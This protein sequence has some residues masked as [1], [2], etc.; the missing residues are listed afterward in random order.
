VTVATGGAAAASGDNVTE[1]VGGGSQVGEDDLESRYHTHCDPRLNAEQSLE[2]AFYVASR[3]RQREWAVGG[4]LRAFVL[5]GDLQLVAM[6][7]AGRGLGERGSPC[8]YICNRDGT[9]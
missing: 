6:R 7:H 2:M 4:Q 8:A 3:L 5:L 1:C 9:G